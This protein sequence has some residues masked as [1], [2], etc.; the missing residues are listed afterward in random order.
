[1]GARGGNP[2]KVACCERK[3]PSKKVCDD[4]MPTFIGIDRSTEC[5]R[6]SKSCCC[7][8][9]DNSRALDRSF[10]RLVLPLAGETIPRVT[11]KRLLVYFA[12]ARFLP[13]CFSEIVDMCFVGESSTLPNAG[14]YKLRM[15]FVFRMGPGNQQ[16]YHSVIG[17]KTRMIR[18]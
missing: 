4:S 16:N 13:P 7:T 8:I 1:M 5:T 17:E 3:D 15:S 2:C 12:E 6:P 18:P 11:P 9:W 10:V 14:F